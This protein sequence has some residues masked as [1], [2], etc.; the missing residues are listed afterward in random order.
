VKDIYATYRRIDDA[1]EAMR[2]A[3]H[4]ERKAVFAL[5]NATQQRERA[6]A[7]LQNAEAAAEA[8]DN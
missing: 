8:L 7:E 4:E 2:R 1:R 5:E 6:A 3:K